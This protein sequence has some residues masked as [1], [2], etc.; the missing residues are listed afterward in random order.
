MI[1]A[2]RPNLQHVTTTAQRIR[3]PGDA[4]SFFRVH[5]IV[6]SQLPADC[7][8]TGADI[9]AT[10]NKSEKRNFASLFVRKNLLG[11]L[12]RQAKRDEPRNVLPIYRSR[13]ESAAFSR[14]G[15]P[16]FR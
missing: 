13:D 7:G 4:S 5:F 2:C 1:A 9:N 11:N 6:R 8:Q 16:I 10:G 12:C 14:R 3:L 15:G